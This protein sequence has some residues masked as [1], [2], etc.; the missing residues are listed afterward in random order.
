MRLI[1]KSLS[2]L[3]TLAW[4]ISQAAACT[5]TGF[6]RDGIDLTA[7]LMNPGSPVSGDVDGTGCNIVIY[8]GSGANGW[9][10]NASIHSSNYYGVVNN[11]A[12][13]QIQNSTVYDI[14]EAPLNGDQHG[15]GIYF[16]AGSN[17]KGNIQGNTVWNYQKGG[18]VV[19]GP[20]A[21][22]NIQSNNVIGQ[23]PINFIAQNGI[24]L[25]YGAKG[26]IQGN[27]VAGNSYTGAGG[28][29]SGGIVVVGGSCY[30]GAI[31]VDTV[32]QQ[33]LGVGNDV[34]IWF[35]NLDANCD[36]VQ[37]P[38]HNQAQN[39]TLRNNSVN[40]TSG[41]GVGAGYQAGISDQ[42]DRD[43][44]QGNSICGKGYTPV[45]PPPY[46][47]LIDITN[48]HAP[49]VQGNKTCSASGPETSLGDPV[50][51]INPSVASGPVIRPQVIE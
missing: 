26:S 8:F 14:G 42:G 24:Q 51:A 9:V 25:A 40:N 31:Q 11:G 6:Y 2:V 45:T 1:V 48:A 46:L 19:N 18:I 27:L 16:A 13:V 12:N 20:L 5:P 30:G 17:A 36:V 44:I 22:S 35:S 32:V 28:T 49:I 10:N 34:G 15:V 41:Y 37:S 38:T 3:L 33:N 7:A 21:S 29:A 47:Y 39:N 43:T 50:N 4:T 23:G